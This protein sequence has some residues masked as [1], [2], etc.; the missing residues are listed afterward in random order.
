[1]EQATAQQKSQNI[2]DRL[3]KIIK[4]RAR[5]GIDQEQYLEDIKK[6][7]NEGAD[8]NYILVTH[9]QSIYPG[10]PGNQKII[11]V[12]PLYE[13]INLRDQQLIQIL[14]N[15]GAKPDLKNI[16]IDQKLLKSAREIANERNIKLP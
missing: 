7:L 1:M 16:N 3:I 6:V 4:S 8:P 14:L 2:N 15:R 13:A 11:V 5:Y 12:T 9:N 10:I